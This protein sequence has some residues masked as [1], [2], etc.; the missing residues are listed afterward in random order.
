LTIMWCFATPCVFPPMCIS[1]IMCIVNV[2]VPT[3]P[4]KVLSMTSLH[5]HFLCMC[6]EGVYV[7][8]VR[9][10][11]VWTMK[12]YNFKDFLM[13]LTMV[14]II[15]SLDLYLWIKFSFKLMVLFVGKI[16]ND[17]SRLWNLSLGKWK[18][19]FLKVG[20]MKK[21]HFKAFFFNLEKK[22]KKSKG[23]H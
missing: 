10:W 3:F 14:K 7:G 6:K 4:F 17:N 2:V 5:N 16:H 13:S 9:G 23:V 20:I 22:T 1:L 21:I 18:C 19:Y 8:Y 12:I 15:A 11:C